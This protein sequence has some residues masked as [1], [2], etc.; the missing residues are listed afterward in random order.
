M[1]DFT[2][3]RDEGSL[4]SRRQRQA[5]LADFLR[6]LSPT[7]LNSFPSYADDFGANST[8]FGD[9]NVGGSNGLKWDSWTTM[10]QPLLGHTLV[11]ATP[12]NHE[13]EANL[14]Y[15]YNPVK[16]RGLAVPGRRRD[17]QLS[18]PAV[19]GHGCQLRLQLNQRDRRA[20]VQPRL[21]GLREPLCVPR[22][23]NERV[24]A[25]V[26]LTPRLSSERRRWSQR[27]GGCVQRALVCPGCGPGATHSS[28]QLRAVRGCVHGGGGIAASAQFPLA[29][30]APARGVRKERTPPTAQ[31][32]PMRTQLERTSTA[33]LSP[34][35]PP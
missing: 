3:V 31:L 35:W 15:P 34:L 20:G 10:F 32:T 26:R 7:F 17:S 1:G 13:M 27:R 2:C 19:H 24:S 12:G 8:F 23:E 4:S 18:V 29:P 25:T 5:S 28:Q 16:V 14:G 22:R 11:I 30:N 33:F 6:R 21:S 9:P